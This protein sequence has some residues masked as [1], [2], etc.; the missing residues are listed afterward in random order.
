MSKKEATQDDG[1]I[2][3]AIIVGMLVLTFIGMAM[4]G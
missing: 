1:L 3:T 2:V 4:A